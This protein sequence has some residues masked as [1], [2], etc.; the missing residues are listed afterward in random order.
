[1]IHSNSVTRNALIV[2][3]EMFALA[4]RFEVNDLESIFWKRVE[5]LNVSKVEVLP[6]IFS[7]FPSFPLLLFSQSSLLNL[8]DP[9]I[10]EFELLQ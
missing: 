7:I 8:L 10:C 6:E 1:M 9:L 4:V 2:L 3:G 5:I